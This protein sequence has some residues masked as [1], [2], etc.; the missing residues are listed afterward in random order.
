VTRGLASIGIE[1]IV[2]YSYD[3]EANLFL[4][5]NGAVS[6]RLSFTKDV[7]LTQR[8]IFQTRTETRHTSNRGIHDRL[9][10][11]QPGVRSEAAL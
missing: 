9:R 7:L 10:A 3:R 11:Q 8:L 2:P 5:Q 1:G 6:A 4:D